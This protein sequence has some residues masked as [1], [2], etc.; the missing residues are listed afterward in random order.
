MLLTFMFT[1]PRRHVYHIPGG[2]KKVIPLVQCNI[3]T[4]GITFFGPPCRV[5]PMYDQTSKNGNIG[6]CYSKQRATTLRSDPSPVT[7]EGHPRHQAPW[8][9]A[10]NE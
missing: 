5:R 7:G 2:P 8:R 3:C 9:L 1:V 10:M 6:A 4:S